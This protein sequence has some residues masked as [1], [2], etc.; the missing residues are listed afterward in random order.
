MLVTRMIQS[1]SRSFL[2]L[3]ALRH[4]DRP[5]TLASL[6]AEA[7]LSKTT[8]HGLLDTLVALGYVR[9]LSEGYWL[10]LRLDELAEP[11]A[12]EREQLRQHYRAL[13]DEAAALSDETVYLATPCGSQEYLYLEAVEG[14]QPRRVQSPRGRR[15]SLRHSAIGHVFLA[16]DDHLLRQVR[17]DGPLSDA[18]EAW[19]RE[20]SARGFA[21]DLEDVE[22][23]LCCL[24]IP[25]RQ[26]GD[27]V[28]AL[29]M[30]GPA[31]RWSPS[32]L[33]RLAKQLLAR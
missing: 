21:L 29:G 2:L 16:N 5:Q 26:R 10:G 18:Q 33:N 7:G 25:L 20:V 17:R 32:R 23:G 28:A 24:A 1:V 6:S 14:R 8:V 4:A 27:C 31:S 13:L 9:R 3:E 22:A 15:E 19:L 11:L 30:A 12:Q